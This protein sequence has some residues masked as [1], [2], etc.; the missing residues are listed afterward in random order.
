MQMKTI[1]T[2]ALALICGAVLGVETNNVPA[3]QLP[4]LFSRAIK[5]DSTVFLANLRKVTPPSEG[6]TD[7]N[8]FRRFFKENGVGLEP[9]RSVY[10]SDRAGMMVYATREEIDKIETL[11]KKVMASKSEG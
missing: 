3:A 5:L 4:M 9:P 1:L 8:L 11:V 6:E 10:F 7:A 2:M